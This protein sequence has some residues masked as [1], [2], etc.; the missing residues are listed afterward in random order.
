MTTDTPEYIRS[1]VPNLY[2]RCLCY[3]L[4]G[5][6]S[7]KTNNRKTIITP[8]KKKKKKVGKREKGIRIET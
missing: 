1:P 2:F 3:P 6:P 8:S 7:V 4:Y 5:N